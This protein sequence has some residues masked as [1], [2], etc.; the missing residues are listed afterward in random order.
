MQIDGQTTETVAG[1]IFWAPKSLQIMTAAMKL[2]DFYSLEWRRQW[3]HTLVLLPG[4]SHGRRSLVGCSPCGHWGLD[5]TERLHFHFSLSCIGE[6]NGNPL[7]CSCLENPRDGG[8]WWLLS[9]GLHRVGHDWSDLAAAAAA[10]YIPVLLLLLLL[11]IG[12]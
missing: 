10:A 1:F 5:T 11:Y 7:P 6:G 3:H 12:I 2:K 9:M 8:A 4:N